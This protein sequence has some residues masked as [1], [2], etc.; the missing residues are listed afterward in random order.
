M[1]ETRVSAK[2]AVIIPAYLRKKLGISPGRKVA[3]TEVNGKVQIIPLS[4]DPM[5][6]LKGCLKTEKSVK[7]LIREAREKDADHEKL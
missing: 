5:A 3:V 2:G 7:E 4:E 6:A 1:K